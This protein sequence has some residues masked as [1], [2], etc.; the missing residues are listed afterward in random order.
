MPITAVLID[1][2]KL[3]TMRANKKAMGRASIISR[4]CD[5]LT[6]KRNRKAIVVEKGN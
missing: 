4:R 6:S 5:P 2:P 3:N 1:I